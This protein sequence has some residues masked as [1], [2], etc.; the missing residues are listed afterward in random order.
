MS[1]VIKIVV[2]AMLITAISELAKRSHTLAGMLASLPL[3]SLLALI[4]L[5]FEGSTSLQLADLSRQIFWLVLPSLLFF[6]VL[7]M[8]LEAGWHFWLALGLAAMS[9]TLA[10]ALTLWLLKQF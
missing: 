8:G 3:T 2:S 10:Y 4:W 5:H 7:W 9:T 1:V 6:V